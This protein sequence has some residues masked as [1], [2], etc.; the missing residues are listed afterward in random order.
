MTFTAFSRHVSALGA[1]A[2]RIKARH[3]LTPQER[4]NLRS[5]GT[6]AAIYTAS[7]GGH[8]HR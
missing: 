1:S 8:Y 5:A 7:L 2:R 6:G 3:T 4:H